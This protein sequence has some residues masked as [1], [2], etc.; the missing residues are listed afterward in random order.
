MNDFH[1]LLFFDTH[2]EQAIEILVEDSEPFIA[3]TS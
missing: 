1:C 2:M 3:V